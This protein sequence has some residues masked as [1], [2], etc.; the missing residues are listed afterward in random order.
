M[1]TQI[2]DQWLAVVNVLS[3]SEAITR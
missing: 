3:A 1:H 2:I